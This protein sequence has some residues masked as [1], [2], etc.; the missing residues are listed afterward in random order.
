MD[1]EESDV[2]TES[3]RI[4]HFSPN[5]SDSMVVKSVSKN[6]GKFQAVRNISFGVKRGECF[7]VLGENGAGKTTMF[8]M[9]TGSEDLTSGDILVNGN[10]VQKDIRTIY[11]DIGYCPQ[12]DGLIDHLTGR[13]T[14]KIVS[15]IRGINENIIDEQIDALSRLL[16]FEKHIDQQISGYSGGT[17]RKLSFAISIVGN[18]LIAFLDEPTTGVDPVSRR[19]LWNAIHMVREAGSSLVLT[20]HS[21][22]ECEALCNRL[23]IMVHGRITCLGSPMHL[24]QK[25]GAG[26]IVHIKLKHPIVE[27]SI[28]KLDR[29]MRIKF[30][31]CYLD[32]IHNNMIVYKIQTNQIKLSQLFGSIERSKDSLFIEDYSI[33]QTSLERIFLSFVRKE[34]K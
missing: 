11:H 13:E 34:K 26:Y 5:K 24:K 31:E 16:F 8:K 27:K 1:S 4:N 10:S 30:P 17:K 22:E 12:F 18:P 21:M 7:G 20:S 15:R 3:N 9:I 32:S 33:C 2:E 6:Y 25:Y 29:F 28:R 19:C 14:L 23:I